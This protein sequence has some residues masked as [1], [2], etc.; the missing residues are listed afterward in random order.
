M[1]LV[2][3]NS[4]YLTVLVA[5]CIICESIVNDLHFLKGLL[6]FKIMLLIFVSGKLSELIGSNS[7]SNKSVTFSG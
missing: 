2:K 5:I 6:G 4:R 7:L 3:I 1:F